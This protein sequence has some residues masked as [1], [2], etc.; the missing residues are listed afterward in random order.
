VNS[1]LKEIIGNDA[2]NNLSGSTKADSIKGLG[3]NDTLYGLSGND[4]IDGGAGDDYLDGGS[5]LDRLNGGLGNDTY[6]L[7]DADIIIEAANEGIDTVIS[8]VNYTLTANV[9]NLTLINSISGTGNDANN[10]IIGSGKGTNTINGEAGDDYLDGGSGNDVIT[11]GAGA[12]S[13][14]LNDLKNGID[15][16]TDFTTGADKLYASAALYGSGLAVGNALNSSQLLIGTSS[17]ATTANQRFVYNNSNGALYFD[18]DGSLGS[19]SAVQVATL[20]NLS[21]L[22]T[23]DFMIF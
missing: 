23:N 7:M 17:T 3:G 13:F 21:S 1:G 5:G 4:Y 14:V 20:S 8:N 16:I 6:R 12:D 19:F 9:E 10:R 15:R 22:S 11:G 18:R 2:D